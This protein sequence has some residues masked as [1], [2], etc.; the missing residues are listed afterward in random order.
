MEKYIKNY[1][2]AHGL[3]TCDTILCRKCGAVANDIH[4]IE[5]RQKN[6]PDLDEAENLISLCRPCHTWVHSNNTFETKQMLRSKQ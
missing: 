3:S 5:N 6:R 1:L 4:H 2:K